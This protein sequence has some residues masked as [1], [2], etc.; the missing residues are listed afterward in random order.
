MRRTQL[1]RI[2]DSCPENVTVPNRG[3]EWHFGD[4]PILVTV[5]FL[6]LSHF[7]D[8]DILGTLGPSSLSRPR[9]SPD[10]ARRSPPRRSPNGFLPPAS[11]SVGE[12]FLA[13]VVS[14]SRR[15]SDPILL[16]GRSCARF[17]GPWMT[18]VQGPAVFVRSALHIRPVIGVG[19]HRMAR[20]TQT[21][22]IRPSIF[23]LRVVSNTSDMINIFSRNVFTANTTGWM[24]A[25]ERRSKLAP[26]CIVDLHRPS[27]VPAMPNRALPLLGM[28][29]HTPPRPAKPIRAC[30]SVPDPTRT[31]L[32]IP[33]RA[34]PRLPCPSTPRRAIPRFTAPFQ[35]TPGLARPSSRAAPFQ[36]N[37]RRTLPGPAAPGRDAPCRP[38]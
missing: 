25:K 27:S 3:Q 26:P 1:S 22:K 2:G 6:G 14:L 13:R 34:H 38:A 36:A 9:R 20:M 29:C 12:I 19:R 15:I 31:R 8:S 18:R 10:V 23:E 21:L 4:C 5:P 11:L 24:D 16:V 32:S 35:P 28:Q 37:P 33:C 17:A 7:G 30:L